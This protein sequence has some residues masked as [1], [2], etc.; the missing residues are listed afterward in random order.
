MLMHTTASDQNLGD[1][2]TLKLILVY[3]SWLLLS[4]CCSVCN[5]V[6]PHLKDPRDLVVTKNAYF[7]L[8]THTKQPLLMTLCDTTAEIGNSKVGRRCICW[9]DGQT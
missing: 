3:L 2:K 5:S 4:K 7:S 6:S 1:D 9:K 8:L